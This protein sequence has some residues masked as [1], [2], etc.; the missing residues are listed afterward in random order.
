MTIR[1]LAEAPRSAIALAAIRLLVPVACWTAFAVWSNYSVVLIAGVAV[2]FS[3]LS[4]WA[5]ASRGRWREVELGADEIAFTDSKSTVRV[6]RRNIVALTV[7][8][9]GIAIKWT[10]PLKPRVAI[11]AKERF[12]PDAWAQLKTALQPWATRP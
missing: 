8:D 10:S 1:F 6:Q 11:L 3:A 7:R 12:R 4:L 5:I 9:A 2:S